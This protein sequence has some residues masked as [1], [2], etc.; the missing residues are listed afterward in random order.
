MV[1]FRREKI[2]NTVT[3]IYGVIGEQMYLI[4]GQE[5]AALIDTGSGV[6]DLRQLISS[7]TDKPV[8]VLVTHAHWDH[9]MG[10]AQFEEVYMSQLDQ[11]TYRDFCMN[12]SI[13][14]RMET[15]TAYPPSARAPKFEEITE[16][17]YIPARSSERFHNLE[18][19]DVFDLGGITLEAI[20]FAG[21]S[22]GSMMFLFREERRLFASDACAYCTML[23]ADSCLGVSSY[24]RNLKAV[25][26]RLNNRYDYVYAAHGRQDPPVELFETVLQV[27]REIIEG[28]DDALPFGV[29]GTSGCLAKAIAQDFTR[30]D[31]RYGNIVYDPNRI[32]E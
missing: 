4:V 20:A 26:G 25:I 31:G 19:G 17:D 8:I 29:L 13:Q 32:M 14:N 23:Q 3:R 16:N 5:R 21:H 7:L 2:S 6:G 12:C 1:Q 24:E 15:L 27:C 9:A 18:D 30:L 28:T 11:D 22:K 10:T